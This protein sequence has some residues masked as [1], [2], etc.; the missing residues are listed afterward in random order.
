MKLLLLIKALFSFSVMTEVNMKFDCGYGKATYG[1]KKIKDHNEWDDNNCWIEANSRFSR[2]EGDG[3]NFSLGY[4]KQDVQI[5]LNACEMDYCYEGAL[6]VY[7]N[8]SE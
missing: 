5:E 3:K 7:I 4:E 8:L 2:L 1:R 6:S